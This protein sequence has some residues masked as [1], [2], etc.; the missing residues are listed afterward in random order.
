M[1]FTKDDAHSIEVRTKEQIIE[2]RKGTAAEGFW[3]PDVQVSMTIGRSDSETVQVTFDYLDAGEG[4]EGF[5]E[6]HFYDVE[7]SA[8]NDD[9]ASP[10]DQIDA[11]SAA[12]DKWEEMNLH[13]E[14]LGRKIIVTG[15]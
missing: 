10:R 11:L 1:S 8:T 5:E 2:A 4:G 3:V 9:W 12:V 6:V 15:T 13:R 7:I 14:I